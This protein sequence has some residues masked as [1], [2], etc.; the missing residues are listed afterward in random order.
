MGK[1]MIPRT[2]GAA[3]RKLNSLGELATATEWERA[4]I[5]ATFVQPGKAGRKP[6]NRSISNDYETAGEFAKRGIHGLTSAS[7]VMVYYRAW[8]DVMDEDGNITGKRERPVAGKSVELP[9]EGWPPTRT[10][11]DGYSTEEGAKKTINRIIEKHGSDVLEDAVEANPSVVAKPKVAA[12]V[13]KDEKARTGIRKGAESVRKEAAAKSKMPRPRTPAPD[14]ADQAEH[15]PSDLEI[16]AT[17]MEATA[18][19]TEASI[20]AAKFAD[21]YNKVWSYLTAEQRSLAVEY[22]DDV[23]NTWTLVSGGLGGVTDEALHALID[24]QQ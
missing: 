17:L 16:T 13:V 20:A 18:L 22:A 14:P 24:N 1:V 11:T 9:T 12:A 7:H 19:A 3:E 8:F 6:G 15:V 10:G 4:A 23:V 5:V 21:V 2:I